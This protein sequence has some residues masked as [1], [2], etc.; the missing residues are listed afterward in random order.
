MR[1]Q[2]EPCNLPASV[3]RG[4]PA[5]RGGFESRILGPTPMRCHAAVCGLALSSAILS[6]QVEPEGSLDEEI[7]TTDAAIINGSPDTS[8]KAVVWLYDES[9]GSSCTGTIIKVDGDTGYVLTAAHCNNMDYV[10]VANNYF[11]CFDQ[12]NPGCEATFDVAQQIYHPSYNSNDPGQGYDFSLIRF[13]GATGWPHW[14]PAAQGN[15][16]VGEGV[17]V[18][19]VGYGQT[20]SGDNSVRR[21]KTTTVQNIYGN[22]FFDH[23]STV[24]F[25]DSGGPAIYNGA[26]VGVSSFVTDNECMDYGFSG[27]VR[28]V[29]TDWIEPFTGPTTPPTTTSTTGATTG[30]SMSTSSGTGEGGFA[31][32]GGAPLLGPDDDYEWYPGKQDGNDEDG[33]STSCAASPGAG[34]SSGASWSLS[35]LALVGLG[36]LRRRKR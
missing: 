26:V 28:N 13:T 36:A 17:T 9:A 10:V 35:L 24:C 31:G 18:D 15:D 30:S 6:C 34:T 27:R 14:I 21:H 33:D 12:G 11:D 22:V 3:R 20:E 29:Y 16:G 7:A 23:V 5:W 19:I 4:R 25:G 1:A 2:P 32:E 8:T